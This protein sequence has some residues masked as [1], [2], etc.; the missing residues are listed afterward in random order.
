M[1]NILVTGGAG[2]IGSHVTVR[3]HEE[4]Y[5]PI[6]LDNFSNSE[7]SVL[8]GLLKIT[9]KEFKLYEGDILDKKLFDQIFTENKI[10]GVIHFAAKKAVGESVEKP[11]NYYKNN[12]S[13]LITLLESMIENGVS[14]L[15]FSSSCTVYGEPDEL[16]VTEQSSIK[17]ANSPYGNTKQIGEEIIRD[18]VESDVKLKSIALRY[19]NPIGAHPS[20]EIGELPLGVPNNLVPFITQTAAGLRDSL[21]VFGNDYDTPDGTCIRDY[22][23]VMDLADAHVQSLKHL[24]SIEDH[25]YFDFINIGTGTGSTVLEVINSFKKMTGESINYSIGPKRP[26][27]V[28][29]IYAQVDKSKALL[30]WSTRY[31]LD[32]AIRDSWNWQKK[33]SSN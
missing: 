21:T 10:H 23:H 11:L 27:D 29:K 19:F 32:D 16:P 14:D 25:N 17:P 30:N 3:L 20:S 18:V 15:V 9:R 5:N 28:E 13:G 33:L 4:G 31:T 12:L 26:G 7:K 24:E 8:A 6:I 1:K 2:Y 22:I